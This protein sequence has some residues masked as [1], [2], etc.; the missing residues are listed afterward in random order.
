M[1]AVIFDLY[2]TLITENHPEWSETPTLAQRLGLDEEF[3][4][5]EW[6]ARYQARMTGALP[7]HGAVLR[8]I[9]Q[10]AGATPSRG[11][12]DRLVAERRQA[13]AR[14]FERVESEMVDLLQTLRRRGLSVGLITNCTDEE[15]AA[16]DDSPFPALVDAAVFSCRVGVI[17]PEAEIYTFACDRLG[18]APG[19]AW[20]VGDGGSDELRGARAAGLR[21][22]WATW[23]IE[24]W[25]WD[26]PANVA[27]T[28]AGFPRCRTP[29]E[30]ATL[31]QAP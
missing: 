13:K 22:V 26:W 5:R 2:E 19:D 30:L 11:L 16:W 1:R 18:V 27:E 14:P 6:R 31:L 4:R 20:F 15:V 29:A 9:C 24:R 23:F 8:E 10:A 28:A 21:P 3:C 12:I 7:D 17:K 25:P